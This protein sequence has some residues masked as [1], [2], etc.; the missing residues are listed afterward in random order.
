MANLLKER[1]LSFYFHA[2][3]YFILYIKW[4]R[5]TGES[6]KDPELH[7]NRACMGH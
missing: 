5:T 3:G 7:G 6:E 1:I 2:G 4:N